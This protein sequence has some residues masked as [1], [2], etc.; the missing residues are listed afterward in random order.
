[1]T[2]LSDK[3]DYQPNADLGVQLIGMTLTAWVSLL[4]LIGQA[5]R[6]FADDY[7]TLTLG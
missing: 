7:K 2:H 4:M 6:T 5:Q 1:M 3:L